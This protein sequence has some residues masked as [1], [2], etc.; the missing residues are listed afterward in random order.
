MRE[1]SYDFSI[2]AFACKDISI[3]SEHILREHGGV[4]D[5]SIQRSPYA[6]IWL[7]LGDGNVAT[8]TYEKEHEIVAWSLQSIGGTVESVCCA[9]APSGEDQ[10]Y[11][12][13]KR[14]ID[15]S[16]VRY[17]EMITG[18][19]S[20]SSVYLI[21]EE[22]RAYVLRLA[23]KARYLV[24]DAVVFSVEPEVAI[25]R[26]VASEQARLTRGLPSFHFSEE[27]IRRAVALLQCFPV[28]LDEGFTALY[29]AYS[30]GIRKPQ[31]GRLIGPD[32]LSL[33]DITVDAGED[34]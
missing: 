2:D 7:V 28:S 23:K 24:K 27:D 18:I 20:D 19:M 21:H 30:G 14:N 4:V 9:S 1:L 32:V 13:V 8:V 25:K 16:D 15:G 3:L 6:I 5:W 17:I 26:Y 29:D 12:V 22:D 31:Y 10:V 33:P 34:D 11:F